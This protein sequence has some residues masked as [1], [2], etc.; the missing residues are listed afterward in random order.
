M[1]EE[2]F[3]IFY[4]LIFVVG[5]NPTFLQSHPPFPLL[6]ITQKQFAP[7][8]AE[9]PDVNCSQQEPL[10]KKSLER[11]STKRSQKPKLL[12]IITKQRSPTDVQRQTPIFTHKTFNL[13]HFW[14]VVSSTKGPSH[15]EQTQGW[16][17]QDT[18]KG[19]AAN[20]LFAPT[21]SLT[22][23]FPLLLFN[24]YISFSERMMK[25]NFFTIISL[26]SRI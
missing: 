14:E 1:T 6:C 17:K 13:D 15:G 4:S 16:R 9:P 11:R 23:S 19:A 10:I 7:A 25:A 18:S 5:G 2:R 20:T 24:K 26:L 8:A 3:I 22:L 21:P 12:T